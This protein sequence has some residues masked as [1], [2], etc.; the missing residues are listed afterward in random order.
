MINLTADKAWIFRITHIDNVPWIL[1]NGLHC[2]NS[3]IV[4]P[5]FREIGNPDLIKKR[6]SRLVP[7]PP[8]GTLSDYV[9]F[10]F[11]PLSPMLY[12]IKTGRNGTQA[13]SMDEIVILVSSL[14]HIAELVLPF[15]FTDRHAYPKAA[16]YSYWSNLDDLRKIDWPILAAHD[17]K[18]DPDD[19]GKIDRYQAEALI[20]QH[21]PVVALKGLACFGPAQESRLNGMLAAAGVSLKVLAKHEWYF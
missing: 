8:G 16:E 13:R 9:P 7:I 11:T 14:Y 17:F 6:A 12:N 19:P 5:N 3:K 21:V 15:V 1:A 18:R 2:P 20:H 10:Y 4:D